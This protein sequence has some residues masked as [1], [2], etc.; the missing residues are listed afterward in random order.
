MLEPQ[1]EARADAL[2]ASGVTLLAE[3]LDVTDAVAVDALIG[4]L[5]RRHG[6]LAGVTHAAVVLDD[7][8]IAGLD[9][10]RTS[11]VLAPKV[12]GMDNLDRATSG[13]A[14]DYFVAFSSVSA[15]LGNPGQGAYAAA[16]GYIQGI[17]ARR[18][19]AGLP[20]LAVGWGAIAD[21]RHPGA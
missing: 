11:V 19:A 2:R 16:N 1:L 4:R 18:R 6:R 7:G 13:M 5:E 3:T 12:V 15:M 20:G 21:A 14:L 10:E 8:L 17:M 9:A